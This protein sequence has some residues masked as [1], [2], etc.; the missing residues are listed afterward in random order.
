M[1]LFAIVRPLVFALDPERAHRLTIAALKR[2]PGRAA[3]PKNPALAITLAGLTFPS[4]VG[5]AAG[6]DKDAEVPDAMLGLGFGFVEVGTVTPLPQAGN[7]KPRLFRLAEDRAVINRMGFNNRGQVAA[8][9][10][11][12]SRRRRGIVGVNVGANKDATDRVSDY[13]SGVR[14]MAPV[15]DYLTINISS[16]NTPGLRALQSGDA[17]GEL[18]DAVT[19]VRAP[20]GPP[21]FLKVAPDLE[22]A[23]IDAVVKTA[24]GRIDGLIIG[25][26]TLSRPS[27]R[28]PD[29][30]EA[31]GLSGAPLAGLALQRLRDFRSAS[32]GTLPLVAAGGIETA[33]QA[34]ERIKAGASLVQLYSALVYHG[35]GLA[36]TITRGLPALMARDGFTTIAEAIGSEAR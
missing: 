21:V 3:Q 19:P 17:L 7:P 36:R 1:S 9:A 28:S 23:E 24:I 34:W 15:A 33:E 12:T 5:L 29:S 4:P 22:P 13:V 16:P 2:L 8:L 25:N 10:R 30:G 27:L 18:L 20:S 31:G 26:T 14:L 32:G 35:P 11:L 6:F